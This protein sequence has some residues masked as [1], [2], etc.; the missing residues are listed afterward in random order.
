MAYK[1]QVGQATLSGSTKFEQVL[2]AAGGIKMS[3]VD[4][5]VAAP[6]SDSIVFLDSDGLMKT[7]SMVDY[8]AL[9]AGDGLGAA[10]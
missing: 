10:S 7:D 8:A 2:D 6:N 5:A 4:A 9:I 3:G 1:F